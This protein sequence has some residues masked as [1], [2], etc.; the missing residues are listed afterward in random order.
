MGSTQSTWDRRIE[1]VEHST[2]SQHHQ[3][4]SKMPDPC[5]PQSPSAENPVTDEV[6]DFN[7]KS[8]KKTETKEKNPLPTKEVI[9]AE[10]K[11]V[12]VTEGVKGFG[13]ESLKKTETKE[14][15]PLPT[16]EVIEAEMKE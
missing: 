7:R 14:K 3:K 1:P 9:E 4:Q 11:E 13:K 5:K 10:K 15:N 16:K 6:K 8:L 2:S 12:A